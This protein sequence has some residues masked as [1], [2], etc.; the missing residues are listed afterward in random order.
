MK[1]KKLASALITKLKYKKENFLLV[2]SDL[3]QH[4]GLCY[5]L[6]IPKAD[7]FLANL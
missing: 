1:L 6:L 2:N 3:V 5:F 7:V 4:S